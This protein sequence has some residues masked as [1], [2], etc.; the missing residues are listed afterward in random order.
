MERNISDLLARFL[1]TEESIKTS[2]VKETG[3]MV[4]AHKGVDP[5]QERRNRE[6]TYANTSQFCRLPYSQNQNYRIDKALESFRS[7]EELAESTG[8]TVQR[9]KSH[10][11]YILKN[12]PHAVQEKQGGKVRFVLKRPA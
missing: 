1:E 11:S 3:G 4:K 2:V 6:P 12:C 7:I 5:A 9:I 10:I 8:C